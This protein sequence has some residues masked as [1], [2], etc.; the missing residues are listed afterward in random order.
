[1]LRYQL[2]LL[3]LAGGVLCRGQA[4]R[5]TP[6]LDTISVVFP[7]GGPIYLHQQTITDTT[8]EGYHPGMTG[9]LFSFAGFAKEAT[10]A[11]EDQ[12]PVM[13]MDTQR[14]ERF[15]DSFAAVPA[16]ASL[17]KDAEDHQIVIINEAHH[18]PRHRVFTR[19]LLDGLYERGYRHFGLETLANYPGSDSL[20]AAM[21]YPTTA[22]GYYTR[23]PQFAAMVQYARD[24]GFQ[25]F[26]YE[27]DHQSGDTPADRETKQM[28]NIVGYRTAHPQ[29]KLLLHVGYAHANEGVLGGSWGRAMAP[30]L[31]DT[32]GLDPLTINQTHFREMAD[33]TLERYEYRAAVVAEPSVFVNG[34][35][36][37][38]NFDDE[39]RW[40]DRYV[41][42]PRTEYRHGRP[43][44]VFTFDRIPVYLEL[45]DMDIEGPYLLQAYRP[46]DDMAQVVPRDVVETST[47]DERA[48]ALEPGAYRVLI[49]S[50]HRRQRVADITVE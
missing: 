33:T 10:A 50:P 11:M 44:Y 24:I 39:V 49:L 20:I 41:F 13:G 30:R 40:F 12:M 36:D 29:D 7:G 37:H 17:L 9:N 14:Y 46:D 26:G 48:L 19:S 32:I 47:E 18:E 15:V 38:W 28:E 34:T 25:L 8:R 16:V 6:E 35:G 42:H 27:A 21:P 4:L 3:C 5:I 45:D 1:M 22:G 2:F 23:D 31:A 43:D